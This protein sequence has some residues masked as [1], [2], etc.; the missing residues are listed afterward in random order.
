VRVFILV[1]L[2]GCMAPTRPADEARY[3]ALGDSYTIGEGVDPEGRWPVV[4]AGH[5]RSEGV[6]LEEPTIVATTGWTTDELDA[7]IDD[8][9]RAGTVSGSYDLVTL[10]IGVNNQYRGREV[11]EYRAEF[12]ALLARA[13][14]FAG[15]RPAAVVVLSIPDWGVTPFARGAA[16][17]DPR[18]G[19]PVVAR[20]IDAYNS[21]AREE[22]GRAGGRWVDVTALSRA[23]PEELA[24]DGL[25][26]SAVQYARWAEAALP[27]ARAA[28]RP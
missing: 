20:E 18:R 16:A 19:G 27:E 11:E 26:P 10:L 24:A 3:L 5:L 15:A 12:R 13:V 4:L 28:L 23:H 6:A 25:H 2:A 22:V 1:L 8:A 7:A 21:V 9:G 14:A 17:S